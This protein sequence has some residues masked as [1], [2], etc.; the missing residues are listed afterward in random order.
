MTLDPPNAT[1]DEAGAPHQDEDYLIL[2]TVHSAKGQEWD[3]VFLL[4]V[5]DGTFPNEFATKDPDLIEEE[6]RLLYVGMTRA[7]QDL[8]LVAPL[9]F[10]VTQQRKFGEKHLYGARSRFLTE[11]MLSTLE[12]RS[13]PAAATQAATSGAASRVRVDVGSKL[14]SMWDD[15]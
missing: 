11:P 1:G 14:L 2:S 7:K 10:Y 13:W 6:R 5:V 8:H 3:S 9:R 12:G 4:N 15:E